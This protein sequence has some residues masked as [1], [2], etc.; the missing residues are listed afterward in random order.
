MLGLS[1]HFALM[2]VK[3]HLARRD[4]MTGKIAL[5]PRLRGFFRA[6]AQDR[7]TT[8]PRLEHALRNK[9]R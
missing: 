3:R 7:A 4:T 5:W 1:G 8:A 9:A 6:L 2:K